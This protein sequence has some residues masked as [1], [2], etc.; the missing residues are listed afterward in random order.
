MKAALHRRVR[1]A[2]AVVTLG[3]VASACTST[4]PYAVIVNGTRVSQAH[5]FQ[6]LR[7]LA[8]NRAFVTEYNQSAQQNGRD[9]ITTGAGSAAKPSYSQSFVAVVLGTDVQAAVVHAE[10]VRRH[11]TPTAQAIA[12]AETSAGQQ[13]GTGADGK[14]VY[15]GFN[16]WFRTLFDTRQAETDALRKALGNAPATDDAAVQKFYNDNPKDFIT[17]QCV[18]HILVKTKDEATAIKAQID[19][20]ADFGAL[21][22]QKSTDTGSAVK[23]GDLG[24][25]K[26]GGFVAEFEAVA[27]SIAL[28]KVSDPVQSQFGYH[29]IKVT[30]RT[31]QP[32]D[33]RTKAAIVQHLQSQGD[34]LSAFFQSSAKTLKVQVNPAYGSWDTQQLQIVPPP[35]PS[36]KSGKP[37][38]PATT[39]AP[40]AGQAPAEAPSAPQTP[41]ASA[42]DTTP[43]PPTPPTS[44]P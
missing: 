30:A 11:I 17:N 27:D 5:L 40:T 37:T 13:F 29:I 22:K 21:A 36:A 6:E 39:V 26:P 32:L 34:A 20:G 12:A 43:P 28:N 23:G 8:A 14:P 2:A 7:A 15:A 42:P 41:P 1:A 25:A 35:T 44:A 19:G 16:P 3:L 33:A 38:A 31:V 4:Q 24:C 9:P 18:S 10:I